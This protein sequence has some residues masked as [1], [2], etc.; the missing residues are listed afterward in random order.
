MT[1]ALSSQEDPLDANME[2]VLPSLHQWHRINNQEMS[3][4]RDSV[5]GLT[6]TL[7]D[8]GTKFDT[9]FQHLHQALK[10]NNTE[11]KEEMAFTFIDVA[12][13]LLRSGGTVDPSTLDQL[14]HRPRIS[15]YP[16]QDP[17]EPMIPTQDNPSDIDSEDPAEVHQLFRMVPKH[18]VL[19][20][21]V[22]EWFGTGAYEDTYGGI[23][24]RN[25]SCKKSGQ[26]RK[27]TGI[28]NMHYSRTE[29]TVQAVKEYA[30]IHSLDKYVAA[31]RLQ[32]VY[33]VQCKCSV[34]N[35]VKWA[36]QQTPPL[37][38]TRKVRGRAA[39]AVS[40]ANTPTI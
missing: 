18:L 20:D 40:R 2:K 17:D 30:L 28:N 14:V 21:L 27:H 32:E 38:R 37:V 4:L 35:F 10:C 11:L 36:Q 9:G 7:S 8:W 19:Q 13:R 22:H 3:N 6:G 29:R 15:H 34:T 26:W 25:K 24:G 16:V 5:Q 23:E 31:E 12:R 1:D 33:E 39:A